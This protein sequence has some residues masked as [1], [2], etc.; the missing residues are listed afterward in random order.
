MTSQLDLWLPEGGPTT[1]PL[2]DC[3]PVPPGPY[4]VTMLWQC[5]PPRWLPPYGIVAGNGQV[6]AGH[7]D[8]LLAAKLIVE[9][10]NGVPIDEVMERD[11]E[12]VVSELRAAPP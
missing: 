11:P 7:I 6:I 4:R 5:L 10:L 9:R 3:E 2:G 12:M 8:N 1:P